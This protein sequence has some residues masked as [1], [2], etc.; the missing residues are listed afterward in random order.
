MF[1]SS[2]ILALVMLCLLAPGFVLA[3]LAPIQIDGY[4]D[5]W[6]ALTPVLD[7]SA[8][9]AGPVDFGRVWVANDQDYLY[10]RFE[11]EGEVQPDEQQNMRLYL[12]TDMN[13]GTGTYFNGIGAELMWEFGWREGTFKP[14]STSY[15][16]E[17]ADIELQMGP[18]VSNTEFEIALRRDAIPA[19]GQHLFNGD[20]VRFI[21]RD[22][23]SGDVAPNSGSITY[24][25]TT[26]TIATPSLALA[27]EDPTHIRIATWNVKGDGLFD[28]GSAEDAQGRMLD[29]MDPDVLIVNEVWDHN[30]VDVRNKIEQHL[31]SGA[32]EA[33]YSVMRDAGNV[34]VSRYP[35]LQSWEV[36]PGYRITAALLDLGEGSSK[37][38]LVIAN[39]WRC[40]TADEDRQNE[41]DSVIGFLRDAKTSGGVITL[42]EGTPFVL[43]G[44]LN[45]VGWRQQLDTI[46]TGDIQDEGTYGS[47]DAPDWNGADF[48]HPR[49]RQPDDRATYTW[50]NDFSSYYPG[51]LDW[52]LYADSVLDVH[53]H[54]ILETRTMTSATL[55][56]NGLLIYDTSYASDHAPR[57]A[58]FTVF[59]PLAP[60][61]VVPNVGAARLLPNVPNPFNP[62]TELRFELDTPGSVELNVYDARGHLVQSLVA[63]QFAAGPHGVMWDGTDRA[64]R[65]VASGVYQVRLVTRV[66]AET[67]IKTQSITLVE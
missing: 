21:L 62:S 49:S 56:A 22:T 44:D 20:T 1:F 13:S 16:V 48:T 59:D 53:N 37:D 50:R 7:D 14:A 32:G 61:P 55:T 36:N 25:F 33:W 17:Q 67:I 38:L 51:N 18:T 12:D 64:G 60:V 28:G 39:H 10:I 31:P 34:I 47:D 46:I 30:A 66:G 9:D 57:V 63:G 45:L 58:D 43:G 26:G 19:G 42:P 27:K 41:A 29:A 52:I 3:D 8:D 5:D 11:T 23:N 54:F 6:A 15:T 35:I 4:F 40:C 2:R 24:T 65:Q